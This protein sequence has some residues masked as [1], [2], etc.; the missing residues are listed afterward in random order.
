[1]K[2]EIGIITLAILLFLGLASAGLAVITVSLTEPATGDTITDGDILLN[3]TYGGTSGEVNCS[4]SASS[5]TANGSVSSILGVNDSS[6]VANATYALGEITLNITPAF[7]FLEDA[8]DWV[9]TM[10][11]QNTSNIAL[12]AVS[13]SNTGITVDHSTPTAP[14]SVTPVT[15]TINTNGTQTWTATV[16]ARNTTACW[17]NFPNENPGSIIYAM[18][19]TAGV[20]TV[21]LTDIPEGIYTDVYISA[22]DGTDTTNGADTLTFQEDATGS[23]AARAVVYEQSTGTGLGITRAT[24]VG[25]S[26]TSPAIIIGLVV[27][28]GFLF[29]KSLG[30]SKK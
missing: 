14:T 21:T 16:N 27:V 18:T 24:G 28:L 5:A 23:S 8:N 13:D 7:A 22:T 26:G 25:T 3:G 1:M 15:G 20:C 11:C 19:E 12:A 6:E 9:F 2:K 4:W 30:I 29:R 17:L 10:I